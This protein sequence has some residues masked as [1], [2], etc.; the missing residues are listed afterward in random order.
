MAARSTSAS[1]A[2]LRRCFRRSNGTSRNCPRDLPRIAGTE[3]K[4][5]NEFK[6]AKEFVPK[7]IVADEAMMARISEARLGACKALL[8]R[9]YARID[10]RLA[11]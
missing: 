3:A 2:I 10:M 7:D 5:E 6:E 4:W 11:R 8:I 1:S 9:D